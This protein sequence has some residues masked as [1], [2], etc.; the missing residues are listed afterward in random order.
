MTTLPTVTCIELASGHWALKCPF[1]HDVHFHRPRP[2]EPARIQRAAHCAGSG[3]PQAYWLELGA[4]A[5]SVRR[6]VT[7][8]VAKATASAGLTAANKA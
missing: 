6:A 7:N 8:L 2:G 5:N 3:I 4:E 1:C